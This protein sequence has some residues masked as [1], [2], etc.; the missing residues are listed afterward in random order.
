VAAVARLDVDLVAELAEVLHVLQEN[1]L[2]GVAPYSLAG[3]MAPQLWL[4]EWAVALAPS[5]EA[6]GSDVVVVGVRDQ[7]EETGALD[8]RSQLAL[9]VRLGAGDAAGDDLA[10]LGDVLA[11]GV[12]ILVIDLLHALSGELAELAAT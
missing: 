4:S 8:R 9:V 6:P 11:Q 1:Q 2:H 3:H 5:R 12:E 7:R 10:G